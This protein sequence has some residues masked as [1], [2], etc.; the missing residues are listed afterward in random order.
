MSLPSGTPTV[1]KAVDYI[2][3]GKIEELKELQANHNDQSAFNNI[4]WTSTPRDVLAS[5]FPIIQGRGTLHPPAHYDITSSSQVAAWRCKRQEIQLMLSV[6]GDNNDGA[7]EVPLPLKNMI[8]SLRKE[9]VKI[10]S[11]NK[12]RKISP[13]TVH[14]TNL[15]HGIFEDVV[16][17]LAKPSIACL[18]VAMTARS[19]DMK[20]LVTSPVC[21]AILYSTNQSWEVLDFGDIED[22]GLA[23]K[24]S[25]N[26]V[27]S[28]LM[29]INAVNKLKKLK[30]TGC[31]NITGEGL[32]PLNG[33]VVLKD[34]DL[35]LV[36]QHESPDISPEPK[37]SEEV[38]L[39]ILNSIVGA[40]GTLLEFIRLP[41]VWRERKASQLDQF[42]E[43]FN[44]LSTSRNHRCSQCTVLC[45]EVSRGVEDGLNSALDGRTYGIQNF[46]CNLCRKFFCYECETQE[47]NGPNR[48]CVSFCDACEGDYCGN[49]CPVKNCFVCEKDKCSG[50]STIKECQDCWELFCDNCSPPDVEKCKCGGTNRCEGCATCVS[51][52]EPH[53]EDCFPVKL[54]CDCWDGEHCQDCADL[55]Q[56]GTCNCCLETGCNKC[57]KV[58][59]CEGCNKSNCSRCVDGNDYDVEVCEDCGR[60]FCF[61]CRLSECAKD[62]DGA[63]RKCAREVGIN[64]PQRSLPV[65]YLY[66]SAVWNDVKRNNPTA[67]FAKRSAIIVQEFRS[68]TKDEKIYWNGKAKREKECYKR[69]IAELQEKFNGID[70][71]SAINQH[72]GPEFESAISQHRDDTCR[73]LEESRVNGDDCVPLDKILET[74]KRNLVA[75]RA[76]NFMG[77]S[78]S[79][80]MNR[81]AKVEQDPINE[82]AHQLRRAAE[83]QF[84]CNKHTEDTCRLLK[85]TAAAGQ[86]SV[87]LDKMQ[88][89]RKK[90]LAAMRA[91]NIMKLSEDE[92][93]NRIEQAEAEAVTMYTHQ[94]QQMRK[95]MIRKRLFPLIRQTQPELAGKIMGML[96]EMDNSELLQLLKSPEALS[97]KIQEALEVLEAQAAAVQEGPADG[98]LAEIVDMK[99]HDIELVMSEGEC[100]RA[101]AIKALQEN[102]CDLINA[103]MSLT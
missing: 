29:H 1:I 82:Y 6:C 69:D 89:T 63:C 94:L 85:T 48:Q 60:G 71:E 14:I 74:R 50:C 91:S 20:K 7:P 5:F 68:L 77:L 78:E 88:D 90:N 99:S 65:F 45:R 8:E 31:V 22:D 92:L 15:P 3:A 70:F 13:Q 93:L 38:T 46:N 35:S 12:R 43:R 101:Q 83:F 56:A 80:M 98:A 62:W 87:P 72:I 16:K 75:M 39:P 102:D 57:I 59:S 19:S 52:E 41:K 73:I 26:D 66:H 24:L 37:I 84:A 40:E 86:L 9:A 18:A 27:H 53:C 100:S 11:P 34:I 25:D 49:C 96:L 36:A 103:I 44:L 2:K 51:C 28:I 61:D 54:Y 4:D 64:L 67:G 76:N 79:Y 42:I 23:E 30:L 81:F 33:S 10:I 58:V 55:F 47:E 17:Y 21:K 97:T 32:A 95:N